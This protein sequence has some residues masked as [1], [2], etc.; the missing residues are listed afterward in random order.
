MSATTGRVA[1]FTTTTKGRVGT[2]HVESPEKEPQSAQVTMT[3][4]M[5]LREVQYLSMEA[6]PCRQECRGHDPAKKICCADAACS[7][8]KLRTNPLLGTVC[9]TSDLRNWSQNTGCCWNKFTNSNRWNPQIQSNKTGKP[10]GDRRAG[11]AK[12][13][14][15]TRRTSWQVSKLQP[16]FQYLHS[17]QRTHHIVLGLSGKTHHDVLNVDLLLLHQPNT[18]SLN[19]DSLLFPNASVVDACGAE[20]RSCCFFR[21]RHLIF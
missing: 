17:L 11:E 4:T 16:N 6:W 9:S 1:S 19:A 5:T 3:V 13:K 15:R 7:V 8:D 14:T 10:G 18:K 12:T 20:L 2:E 21:N